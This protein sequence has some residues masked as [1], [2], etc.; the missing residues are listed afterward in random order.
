MTVCNE[1]CLFQLRTSK[2]NVKTEEQLSDLRNQM[3]QSQT[4]VKSAQSEVDR[5]LELLKD[6]E[7]EKNEKDNQL[8]EL[9]ELVYLLGDKILKEQQQPKCDKTRLRFLSSRLAVSET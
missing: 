9:Q 8:K 7:N 1:Y 5:L 2:N 6:T 3:E 4:E